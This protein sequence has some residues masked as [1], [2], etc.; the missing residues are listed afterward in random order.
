MDYPEYVKIS[1]KEYKINSDFRVAIKCNEIAL[2]STIRDYERA[3]AVIYLL[4][5]D[6]AL[7]DCKEK[8]DLYEKF[9]KVALKYLLCEKEP[10]EN[11]EKQDMDF[12]EDEGYKVLEIK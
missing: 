7:D 4:F 11:H 10:E 6:E 3:M 8:P 2:D 1:G 5:G 9:L 12:I